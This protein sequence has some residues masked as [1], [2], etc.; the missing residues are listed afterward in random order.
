VLARAGSWPRDVVNRRAVDET[1]ARNG[2]WGN[3]RPADWLQ[4]LTPG[5]PPADTDN[6]G[7]PN[8]WETA[9]GLNPANGADAVTVRPSGYTAIEEYINE[10]AQILEAAVFSDGFEIGTVERWTGSRP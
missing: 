7:M 2:S 6:D 4:G 3:H 10:M 1:V 5:T 8:G 9:H